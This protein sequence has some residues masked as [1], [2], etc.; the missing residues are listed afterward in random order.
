MKLISEKERRE[1]LPP[2]KVTN[3]PEPR[4]GNGGGRSWDVLGEIKIR[5]KK[6][7]LYADTTWG[8]YY[9]FTVG[10]VGFEYTKDK[11]GKLKSIQNP[12]PKNA[13]WYKGDVCDVEEFSKSHNYALIRG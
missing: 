3:T 10:Y 2:F 13:K 11:K 12:R 6:T 9:Y 1:K 7:A 4:M 8:R 5:G